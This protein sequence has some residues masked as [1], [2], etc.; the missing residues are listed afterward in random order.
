MQEV[1]PARLSSALHFRRDAKLLLF[2]DRVSVRGRVSTWHLLVGVL[3]LCKPE[4]KR[5]SCSHL[6][7]AAEV[8]SAAEVPKSWED[9]VLLSSTTSG[10]SWRPFHQRCP[11]HLCAGAC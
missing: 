3:L 10:G 4:S 6:R 9:S 5:Q 1:A 2:G 8:I 11:S 7:M